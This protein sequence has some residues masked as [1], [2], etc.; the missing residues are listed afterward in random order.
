MAFLQSFRY[1]ATKFVQERNYANIFAKK[2]KV[3]QLRGPLWKIWALGAAEKA[4][5]RPVYSR[6]EFTSI[7]WSFRNLLFECLDNYY[8]ENFSQVE[9]TFNRLKDLKLQFSHVFLSV[10]RLFQKH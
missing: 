2:S 8:Y 10:M 9:K 6:E 1:C 4:C 3:I 7:A 5:L